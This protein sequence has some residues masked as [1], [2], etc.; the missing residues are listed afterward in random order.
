MYDVG[1]DTQLTL[2]NVHTLDYQSAHARSGPTLTLTAERVCPGPR[3]SSDGSGSSY[4]LEVLYTTVDTSLATI[5]FR[6]RNMEWVFR[7]DRR[8]I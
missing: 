3:D 1:T 4:C 7:G 2:Y 6:I 8:E 5:G